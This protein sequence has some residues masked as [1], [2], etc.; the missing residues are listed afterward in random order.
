MKKQERIDLIEENKNSISLWRVIHVGDRIP[1]HPTNNKYNATHFTIN[2]CGYSDYIN[3]YSILKA[4]YNYLK[5]VLKVSGIQ[6]YYGVHGYTELLIPIKHLSHES[7]QEIFESLE[8]YPVLDDEELSKVE[9]EMR[10]ERVADFCGCRLDQGI[11]F[12]I[13]RSEN[14]DSHIDGPYWYIDEDSIM[15]YYQEYFENAVDELLKTIKHLINKNIHILNIESLDNYE[16]FKCEVTLFKKGL[17]I[18]NYI[19]ETPKKLEEMI[20][21]LKNLISPE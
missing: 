6:N 8:N 2:M 7:I 3:N 15:E 21:Q 14:I 1:T 12:D 5:D 17:V 10:D 11:V 19:A 9:L 20:V 4:N 13:I 16:E 18:Y